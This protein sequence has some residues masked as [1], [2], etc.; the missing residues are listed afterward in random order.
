[1]VE[2]ED[3][4]AAQNRIADFV[5]PTPLRKSHGLSRDLN[6]PIWL[7]METMH[8]TGAFKLRGAANRLLTLDGQQK[9]RGVITV[10]SGNHGRAVAYMSRL[11]NIR[12]VVCV[13]NIVPPEKVKGLHDFGAEVIVFG[14][15]QDEADAEARRIADRDNLVFISPF[16]DPHVIAGQGTIGLELLADRPDL[17]IVFIQLSGGGLMSGVAKALKSLKPEIRIVGVSLEHGAAMM[18]SIKAGRIVEVDEKPS[19]ADALPGPIPTDNQYTFSMC[20]ELVD[21]FVQVREREIVDAMRYALTHEKCL[22]EGGAA[23]GIAA[24]RKCVDTLDGR[25]AATLLTGNN[26]SLDRALKA[27]DLDPESEPEPAC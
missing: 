7:K 17:E 19:I 4:H 22:I 1:M 24:L 23:A 15:N 9:S 8:D 18:E 20:R 14:E 5:R 2:L 11:L 3:I 13:T 6:A 10:S 25:T 21:E 26:I 27:M 12:A 16:D